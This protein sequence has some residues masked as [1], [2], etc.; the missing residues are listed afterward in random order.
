LD[1]DGRLHSECHINSWVHLPL[2]S[3]AVRSRGRDVT[4]EWVNFAELKNATDWVRF[5]TYR[6]EG[7]MQ[8]IVDEDPELFFDAMSMFACIPAEAKSG[9]A[10]AGADHAVVLHPLPKVPMLVAYWKADGEFE[11]KLTLL[12]DRSAEVN[13]GAESIYMLVTGLLEMLR[14]FMNRH[15]FRG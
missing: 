12:F 11:S 3:Y 2:L 8:T 6:C 15:G 1:Q 10:F 5:F 7:G 4:G 14:R 13:L 9:E